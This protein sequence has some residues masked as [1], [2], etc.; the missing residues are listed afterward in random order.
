MFLNSGASRAPA[1]FR[2]SGNRHQVLG[3]Q[4]QHFA[5]PFFDHAGTYTPTNIKDLFYFCRHYFLTNGVIN[6]ILTKAAEYPVTDLIIQH[7]SDGVQKK[8]E[9]LFL[10]I[11]NYRARGID[12]NVDYQVYGTAFVSPTFPTRKWLYCA[13]CS[14]GYDAVRDRACWRYTSHKFWL[15]C[16]KCGQSGYV[17]H[18]E[19][20]PYPDYHDVRIMRW[21]PE[22]IGAAV[23]P[24]TGHE[25]YTLALSDDFRSRITLGQKDLVATTPNIFL[26]A[27]EK[28][29]A[30]AFDPNSVFHMKRHTVS[31]AENAW[32]TP[33]IMPVLKDLFLLQVLK[34]TTESVA[35]IHGWPQVFIFPQPATAGAD[36]FAV[37]SLADWRA[38]LQAELAKQRID[39]GYYGVLPFPVGHQTIGDS[40][41]NWMLMPEIRQLVEL[42]IVGMGYPVD[43]IF[44]QGTYAGSSVTMR[45]MENTFLNNVMGQHRL[46]QWLAQKFGAFL[47]WDLPSMKFRKFRMA[48]D[49]Q[50]QGMLFQLESAGKISTSTM[51]SEIDIKAQDETELMIKDMAAYEKVEKKKQA[52]IAEVQGQAQMIMGKYQARAQQVANETMAAAQVGVDDPFTQAL[53]S[54]T[55][56]P[57]GITLDAAAAALARHVQ[58]MP[59]DQRRL[60]MSQLAN[61][62]PEMHQLVQGHMP[63]PGQPE[64]PQHGQQGMQP[65]V[66]MRPMPDVLPPRR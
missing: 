55:G 50:R 2:G 38:K 16:D 40:G 34:K 57:Q 42:I 24:V 17:K 36:P 13:N 59:P 62:V 54:P 18:V 31:S 49:L 22:M 44:G 48:D 39:P 28:R 26:S 32:G 51:L 37:S 23:N 6:A 43:L 60:Y 41:R 8:W 27:V 33:A 58:L 11:L 65:P 4:Y 20:V 56:G 46:V 47:N 7:K 9:D 30:L 3:R 1:M 14:A 64:Q 21:N 61:G 35:L 10:G 53:S 12:V 5:N 63:L 45:M 25:S 52:I 66:D 19:D 15:R 29:R